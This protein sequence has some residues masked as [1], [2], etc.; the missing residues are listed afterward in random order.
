MQLPATLGGGGD[1]ASVEPGAIPTGHAET[2]APVGGGAHA[3]E[4]HTGAHGDARTLAAGAA[5]ALEFRSAD[6]SPMLHAQRSAQRPAD[7]PE[8]PLARSSAACASAP[9]TEAT[10][11]AI[12]QV[13]GQRGAA[14]YRGDSLEA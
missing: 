3:S 8:A 4:L 5:A 10:P 2:V 1:S 14:P 7:E 11:G 12:G 13:E 6:P 9:V